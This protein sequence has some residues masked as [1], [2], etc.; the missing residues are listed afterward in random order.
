VLDVPAEH[1]ARVAS[2]VFNLGPRFLALKNAHMITSFKA[3]VRSPARVWC[4]VNRAAPSALELFLGEKS[5]DAGQFFEFANHLVTGRFTTAPAAP[6]HSSDILFVN[7]GRPYVRSAFLRRRT[8]ATLRVVGSRFRSGDRG[9]APARPSTRPAR[10]H[11]D[12][13]VRERLGE[14]R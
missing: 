5:V 8:S 4:F 13:R 9:T 7:T 14:S 3:I 6:F 10:A 12:L 11:V 1:P 2:S